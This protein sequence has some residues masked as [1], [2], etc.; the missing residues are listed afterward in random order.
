MDALFFEPTIVAKTNVT[1]MESCP[2]SLHLMLIF[3]RMTQ[4]GT[5]FFATLQH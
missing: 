3:E 5:K 1:L 2:L 4:R